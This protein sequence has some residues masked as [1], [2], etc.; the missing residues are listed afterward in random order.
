MELK[1]IHV[2]QSK[3]RNPGQ[4]PEMVT[5]IQEGGALPPIL[6]AETEDGVIFIQ[7]GHHR[8]VAYLL[9]GRESLQ[10]GEYLLLQVEHA[11]SL[12]GKLTDPLVLDRLQALVED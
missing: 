8:S 6:L 12:K 7:D 5:T 9:A 3:L 10:W 11:R 4:L 2:G 1:N